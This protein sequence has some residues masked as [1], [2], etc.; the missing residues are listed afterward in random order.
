M[1]YKH[2]SVC[3]ELLSQ[4]SFQVRRASKDG[5]TAACKG[6]LNR[7]EKARVNQP[8]RIAAR[9]AYRQT[10][11]GRDALNRG[12]LAYIKRN[13]EIRKVHNALNNAVR[14]GRV[15][16][17]SCCEMCGAAGRIHGHHDD[18][19]KPLDVQ[20]VCAACHTKIHKGEDMRQSA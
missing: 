18:Y 15:D 5:R 8:H 1:T 9:E 10:K 20:W 11:Q 16:K 7:R 6:C 13:P 3:H 17:P 14:K 12:G 2:C 4:D 19:S